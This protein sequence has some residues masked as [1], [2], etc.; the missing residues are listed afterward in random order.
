VKKIKLLHILTKLELGGAQKNVLEILSG[1]DPKKYDIHL[2]TSHGLLDEDAKKISHIHLAFCPFLHRSLNPF[3][4]AFAFLYLV[5]YILMN[6]IHILHS[7]SSKAGILGRWAARLAGVPVILHTVH[8]WGFQ[9]DKKSFMNCFYIFLERI[10]ARF[11]SRLI[12]VSE[13]D[14]RSGLKA[15]IGDQ[16]KYSL[17]HCCLEPGFADSPS[18][19]IKDYPVSLKRDRKDKAVG[20][21]ACLKRQKNPLDFIKA[22]DLIFQKLPETKFFIAGDGVLRD[23][24][25]NEI[26]KRKLGEVVFLLGWRRDIE[27]IVSSWDVILLTSLWEGLPVALLEAMSLRKPIVA[28]DAGGI[29]EIVQ[30]GENGFLVSC[31]D[32]GGLSHQ[33]RLL[34]ENPD[35]CQKMGEAGHRIATGESFSYVKM[36]ENIE[37]LYKE[38]E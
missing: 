11:T 20:M 21:V 19:E 8:G 18:Q 10:T 1:L 30:D 26:K 17:I 16:K 28:Y 5:G 6:R 35:L 2:I 36:M 23:E 3:L 33:T 24:V 15:G 9:E 13:N 22:A 12:A 37:N 7:H 25:E 4:D 27:K 34:L 32:V 31:G 38:F 29:R 14:I